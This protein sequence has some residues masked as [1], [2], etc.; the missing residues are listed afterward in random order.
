MATLTLLRTNSDNADFKYLVRMLDQTLNGYYRDSQRTYD[1]FNVLPL[2]DTVLIAKIGSEPIGCG[3]FRPF[4]GN[5]VEIKRMFVRN[6]HRG[7][8]IATSILLELE[9]WAGELGYKKSILETGV[10]QLEAI[11]L[12]KKNGYFRTENFGPY[13]GM[14]T[15]VCFAKNLSVDKSE[16]SHSKKMPGIAVIQDNESYGKT[17]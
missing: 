9:R 16:P 13:V 5:T 17:T 6:E 10:Q 8:G 2:L 15:S 12:Y 14:E 4:D 7:M 3:C 11:R 1:K